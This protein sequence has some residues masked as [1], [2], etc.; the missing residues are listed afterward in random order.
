VQLSHILSFVYIII[1]IIIIIFAVSNCLVTVW[2]RVGVIYDAAYICVIIII[3]IYVEQY[4][5]YH[6]YCSTANLPHLNLCVNIHVIV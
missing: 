1:I 2:L 6:D 3:I 5:K 4:V